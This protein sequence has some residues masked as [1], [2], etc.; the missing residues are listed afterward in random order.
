MSGSAD[1]AAQNPAQVAPG[2]EAP[3]TLESRQVLRSVFCARV[4]REFFR[5]RVSHHGLSFPDL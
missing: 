3:K 2:L 4:H 1:L 5:C